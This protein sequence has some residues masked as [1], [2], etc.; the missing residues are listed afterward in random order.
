MKKLIFLSLFSLGC[1]LSLS[2]QEFIGL[3]PEGK[4]PDSKGMDL[5]FEEENQ[6][7]TQVAEPGMYAFFTS[8]EE[9]TGSAVLICPPGGYA[10][11]TYQVAGF[12]FAKWL[13]TIGIDAFVLIHRLPTSPDLVEREKGPVQD[14][15]RAMKILR[16][17]AAEWN[18][19][20]DKIGIMGAS[21]GGHLASLMGTLD[22][23][24][25]AIGDPLDD[26]SFTPGFMIL[27]SPVI[28]MGE[29][30][31]TGS[32]DN[33]LGP[34]PGADKIEK[35]SSQLHVS[36]NTPPAFIVLAEN[37]PVVHP[38]NSILFYQALM[39]NDVPASLHIFPDGQHSIA[40]R[41]N[42]GSTQLWTDLCEEWLM[43]LLEGGE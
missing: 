6:R 42:P 41:N 29:F 36:S 15:Q 21:A 11:L 19:D 9:Y 10:K 22:E 17:N 2:A 28:S 40:L 23:D 14:A 30:C 12:Q 5:A 4:M 16:A 32:R 43:T 8:M 25:S 18:L 27:V 13:N 7:I 3:W 26:V 20:P 37:D 38:M 31:H 1:M 35:Y 39:E 24:F 34:D 33:L